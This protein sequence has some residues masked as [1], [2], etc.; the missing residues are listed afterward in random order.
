MVLDIYVQN[1]NCK[2]ALSEN[3][4]RTLNL[5]PDEKT[6]SQQLKAL[7]FVSSH[8]NDNAELIHF[9]IKSNSV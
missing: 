5:G 2:K 8:M 1:H 3:R 4:T 7:P 9:H 6:G